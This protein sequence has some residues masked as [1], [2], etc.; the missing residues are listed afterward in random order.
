M[1]LNQFSNVMVCHTFCAHV[2]LGGVTVQASAAP[3]AVEEVPLLAEGILCDVQQG[4][5]NG[6][7]ATFSN[8]VADHIWAL[9]T[10]VSEFV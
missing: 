9:R 10:A 8:I 1:N 3:N 7:G 4:E 5:A 2:Q 6:D